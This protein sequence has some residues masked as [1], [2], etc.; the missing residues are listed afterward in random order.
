M[1]MTMLFG[2]R[3]V[4]LVEVLGGGGAWVRFLV[5]GRAIVAV[6]WWVGEGSEVVEMQCIRGE[7]KNFKKNH[8]K[9]SRTGRSG[10]GLNLRFWALQAKFWS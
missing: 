10:A 2:E 1:R 9:I 7:R 4:G 8:A 5:R 3:S 6:G